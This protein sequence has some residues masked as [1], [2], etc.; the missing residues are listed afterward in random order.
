VVAVTHGLAASQAPVNPQAAALKEFGDRV[1]EYVSLHEKV[2]SKLPSFD[3]VPD[4]EAVTRRR[5]ALA[6]GLRTARADAREGDLFTTP[7]AA[8]VKTIVRR[9]LQSREFRDAIAAVEEVAYRTVWVNMSWPREAPRPTIPAR[10]LT[11]LYPLPQD[12]EYRFLDRHLVLLDVDADM[13][14]DLVRNVLPSKLRPSG[15]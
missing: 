3:G 15:R 1:R 13:V 14:V 6:A 5:D 9:D 10:L 8:Q 12:L 11:S 4:A 7:V 2:E